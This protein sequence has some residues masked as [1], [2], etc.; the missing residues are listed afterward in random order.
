MSVWSVFRSSAIKKPIL[1][2]QLSWRWT[3][4]TAEKIWIKKLMILAW[5]NYNT[6]DLPGGNFDA[7]TGKVRLF[8][9][10]STLLSSCFFFQSGAPRLQT[11]FCPSM[12]PSVRPS[13][14]LL[15]IIVCVYACGFRPHCSCPKALKTQL[16]HARDL[17]SR[18][19]GLVF[20]YLSVI[21]FLPHCLSVFL[22]LL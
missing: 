11:P 22:T 1:Y 17:D 8:H 7:A 6:Y 10:V 16:V 9:R 4:P 3:S 14:H 2:W 21:L 19:S 18:A 15:F 20:F 5:K 12:R 13:V